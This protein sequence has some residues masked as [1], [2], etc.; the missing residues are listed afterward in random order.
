MKKIITPF[1]LAVIRKNLN[2]P[3]DRFD[4]FVNVVGGV[5]IK[6]TGADLGFI[7]SL[8]SSF[9]NIALPANSLFVGE[10]GLLGEIRSSF[11]EEKIVEESKRL[12]FKK[13]Y[14][15]LLIKNVKDFA[16]QI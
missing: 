15:S 1:I 6:S 7:A 9:K 11:L 2:L 14:S 16:K 10:V 8:I 5:S 13:I 4:V 3:L 12:G